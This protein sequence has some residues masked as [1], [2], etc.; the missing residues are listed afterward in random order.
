ML[1]MM[2][3]PLSEIPIK[4]L[5]AA[6]QKE[7][8]TLTDRILAA[9]REDPAADTS[10]LEAAIETKVFD[11]YGLTDDEREIIMAPAS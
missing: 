3:I 5:D 8:I 4:Q 10:Q 7:F 6:G 11:L 2:Q 9:K 1:E